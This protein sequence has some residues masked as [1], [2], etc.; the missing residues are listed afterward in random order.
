METSGNV[1]G[2]RFQSRFGRKCLGPG[3]LDLAWPDLTWPGPAPLR[4]LSLD[5]LLA[6]L[7][8]FFLIR[9]SLP[10][11]CR[12]TSLLSSTCSLRRQRTREGR[13]HHCVQCGVAQADKVVCIPTCFNR[14]LPGSTS[15]L[16]PQLH[17]TI[18]Q[19][20]RR[21]KRNRGFGLPGGQRQSQLT[22]SDVVTVQDKVLSCLPSDQ[23]LACDAGQRRQ[24]QTLDQKA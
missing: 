1:H 8:R 2:T 3:G 10:T 9:H 14:S 13:P 7:V 15:S 6:G 12:F 21:K 22:G 18:Y 19:A 23:S 17:C 16:P 11:F 20:G 24:T 4:S 5:H